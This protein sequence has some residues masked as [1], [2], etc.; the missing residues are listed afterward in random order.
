MNDSGLQSGKDVSLPTIALVGSYPP[1]E[2][3]I[4]TFSFDL[5]SA[6]QGDGSLGDCYS[7]AMNDTVGGYQY[8]SEVRFEVNKQQASEYRLAA[9]ILNMN[10]VSAVSIQ[11]EF[12]IYGGESGCLV[13]DLMERLHMPVITTLHTVL[14][15][16][17]SSKRSVM[18]RI[19]E[20]S[21]RLVVMSELSREMLVDIYDV[22]ESRIVHI[23]HGIPDLS[24]VDPAYYKN[25]FKVEGRRV[26]LT[27]GLLSPNKGLEFMVE[28]MPKIV[29]EFP[30]TVYIILGKTHPNV[31]RDHDEAYRLSLKQRVKQLGMQKHVLFHNEFVSLQRLTEYL[32]CADVY[33]T[34]YLNEAQ[35]VSGTLAYAL[36]AGK[37][38][39]S[40]PY[41]YAQE[42]LA[43]GKGSLVP[44]RD[45]DAFSAAITHLF[46]SPVETTSMRKNA[47]DFC[48]KMTWPNVAERYVAEFSKLSQNRLR[49]YSPSFLPVGAGDTASELPKVKLDHLRRLSD[50][51]GILQHAKYTVP[52]KNQGYTTDDNAR[53]LIVA[54]MADRFRSLGIHAHDLISVYLSF[55][56]FAFNE[57]EGR[58]GNFLRYD[59]TWTE[60][61]GSQDCH[62]R[63]LMALGTLV[64]LTEDDGHLGVALEIF[65]RGLSAAE[66]FI[67]PRS[68]A[69]TLLGIHAF[70]HR[71]PGVRTTLRVRD[72]LAE[73]LMS[74]TAENA[75]NDWLWLEDKLT[76]DNAKIPHALLVSGDD[77]SNSEMV[78]L[79][80][81]I[82]EWL[83]RVQTEGEMFVPIGTKG[84]YSRDRKPARYD[85]QPLEVAGMVSACLE[86]FD[87]TGLRV[88]ED[89]AMIALD[90]FLG[91]NDAQT[92][93]YDYASGG[94]YDGLQ[95][96]GVNQNQGAES[97]ISWLQALLTVMRHHVKALPR[98]RDK[99]A[100]ERAEV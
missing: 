64:E 42:M 23:P 1:R 81:R 4:A 21:D 29:R 69:T 65:E 35:A 14:K 63:A 38:V 89:R 62:G 74:Q 31:L 68:W 47:Y 92:P 52:R 71:F 59:R 93:M 78:G 49:T 15:A 95:A 53:A 96:K 19:A 18:K 43:G 20:L 88:W 44:F 25:Q 39:V 83:F 26:I 3:G 55:L 10:R 34:P 57:S 16:P 60:V 37:A 5:L 33:V 56:D 61:I 87:L 73:R 30:D 11:H 66:D 90:W 7:V 75:R 51:T 27:F 58:F 41:W 84:W 72:V 45:A 98:V 36:G 13:L 2:C 85:Q 67:S 99:S 22:P 12:G 100:S 40:T 94:C 46:R 79:G 77:S 76:Y 32:G 80:L 91:R 86:A 28:A 8:P 9:R 82:L 48:R 50:S 97:T 54:T 6:L 70:R 17:T 24:F